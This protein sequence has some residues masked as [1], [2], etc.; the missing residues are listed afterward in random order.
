MFNFYQYLILK[1]NIKSVSI[2]ALHL[3]TS[4]RITFS[5][6]SKNNIKSV[7]TLALPFLKVV[8]A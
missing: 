8:L 4:L 6:G 5:K 1:N 2:F 7:S 3:A